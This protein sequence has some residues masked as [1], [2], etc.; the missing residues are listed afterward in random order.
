MPGALHLTTT[1]IAGCLL[2]ALGGFI[3]VCCH[4]SLGRFFTW[5]VAVRDDHRLI[6]DGP[7]AFVR[8]PSYTGWLLIHAGTFMLLWSPGSY[9]VESG[10]RDTF[11]GK[12][13]AAASFAYCTFVSVILVQRVPQEDEVLRREFGER[14]DAWARNTPF[15]LIPF[16]Y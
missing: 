11:L 15:R 10:L 7:Y 4:R 1:S 6:T 9:F 12:A 5:Q 2:G 13:A 14:W 3:R 16:V 8:H